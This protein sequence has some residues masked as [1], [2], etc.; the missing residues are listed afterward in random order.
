MVDVRPYK[1]HHIYNHRGE[2][3]TLL[4]SAVFTRPGILV[5]EWEE[6]EERRMLEHGV[7][8][9]IPIIPPHIHRS[10]RRFTY[11]Y[12]EL[13]AIGGLNYTAARVQ[14]TSSVHVADLPRKLSLNA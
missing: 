6:R 1:H 5:C 3:N 4:N 13:M 8:I 10:L 7:K 2:Q 9:A 14:F 11:S 12:N